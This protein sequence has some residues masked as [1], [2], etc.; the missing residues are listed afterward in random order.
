M[1]FL[2]NLFLAV[3]TFIWLFLA[4]IF[5]TS[6]FVLI[7]EYRHDTQERGIK[8]ALRDITLVV[9]TVG[10]LLTVTSPKVWLSK[11]STQS[12]DKLPT[13]SLELKLEDELRGAQ[14]GVNRV[15][16]PKQREIFKH[17]LAI[18]KEAK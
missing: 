10:T 2:T 15:P 16:V 9:L 8:L 17:D 7:Y 18:E 12:V 13:N 5:L 14:E 11:E 4:I 3:P 6:V 1:T